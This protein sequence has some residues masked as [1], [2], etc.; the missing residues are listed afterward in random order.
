MKDVHCL[1][2]KGVTIG[3][4]DFPSVY[5]RSRLTR[6][7]AAAAP[8]T[9][10]ASA[11]YFVPTTPTTPVAI[12]W[13]RIGK[14]EKKKRRRENRFRFVKREGSKNLATSKYWETSNQRQS[15]C[16]G[17]KSTR[18]R[19]LCK[20]ERKQYA[21]DCDSFAQER[22]GETEEKTEPA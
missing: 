7:W 4:R 18:A 1:Q 8:A 11:A 21:S 9:S 15:R 19:G 3:K 13:L 14:K 2:F 12:A 5:F 6:C 16:I 10:P 20:G 17:F 22:Q